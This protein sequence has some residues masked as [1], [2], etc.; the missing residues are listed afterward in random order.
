MSF[1]PIGVLRLSGRS[2]S[3]SCLAGNTYSA[4][5]GALGV[6]RRVVRVGVGC[7]SSSSS[8]EFNLVVSCLPCSTY[9]PFSMYLYLG[10]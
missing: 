9:F 3:V 2:K 1:C 6:S 5:Q 10:L 7:L 4:L 8:P